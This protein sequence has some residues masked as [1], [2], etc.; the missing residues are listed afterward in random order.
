VE[1]CPRLT[2]TSS[3]YHSNKAQVQRL[4]EEKVRSILPALT[5]VLQDS[6]LIHL[7]GDHRSG[8]RAVGGSCVIF[9]EHGKIEGFGEVSDEMLSSNPLKHGVMEAIARVAE[10]T[11][12]FYQAIPQEDYG[13]LDL[14]TCPYL[15]RNL[16]AFCWMEPCVMC[17]MA[18]NHSRIE[19]LFFVDAQAGD[20]GCSAHSL[21]GLRALNH[22]FLAV[23]IN[24]DEMT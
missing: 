15:C 5:K 9:G 18:L 23:Q 7:G 11:V 4:K 10:S 22:D 16:F 12:A 19:I 1:I 2:P 6:R 24:L 17:T 20:G 13:Q 14:T 3:L 8:C 21:H